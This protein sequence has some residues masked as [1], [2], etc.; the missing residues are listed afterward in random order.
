[1][2]E[3]DDRV[4]EWSHGPWSFLA[5]SPWERQVGD[6]VRRVARGE[7]PPSWRRN[8]SGRDFIV[9][10][11]VGGR[12]V[13]IRPYRR[14]GMARYILRET[15][16]GWHP[17]SFRE[18]RCLLEL[19]RRQVPVVAPIGAA[20]LWMGFGF[21]GAWLVTL[22]VDH[23]LTF[24]EWLQRRPAREERAHVVDLLAQALARLHTAGARHPD[25]NLRN[26]LVQRDPTGSVRVVLVDFDRVVLGKSPQS[27]RVAL[28]RFWR[29]ARKLDPPA[30]HWTALD[31][32]KLLEAVERYWANA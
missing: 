26:V 4:V 21:Y 14:G 23:S 1:M 22:Y 8:G 25:L 13:V 28:Q 30:T 16:W 17:R 24:W 31:Q 20:A 7:Y 3:L 9:V 10:A 2:S 29:S 15:Y 5:V 12:S 6:L 27:P 11:P 19:H 32:Q 18:F